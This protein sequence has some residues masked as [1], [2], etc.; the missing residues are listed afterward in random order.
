MPTTA[1][2]ELTRLDLTQVGQLNPTV[3]KSCGEI[4]IIQVGV[5]YEAC[6]S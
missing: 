4:T 2:V 5:L 1:V 3:V 6:T